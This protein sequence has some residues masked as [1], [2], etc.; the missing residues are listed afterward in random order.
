MAAGRRTVM[1]VVMQHVKLC[2][3]LLHCVILARQNI[4]FFYFADKEREE[5]KKESLNLWP[6]LVQTVSATAL[7]LFTG[8]V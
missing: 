7:Y 8:S 2:L 4:L 3:I 6:Q 5:G 1:V